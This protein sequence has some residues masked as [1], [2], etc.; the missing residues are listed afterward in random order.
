MRP[1]GFG[2]TPIR[3]LAFALAVAVVVMG[4]AIAAAVSQPWLGLDLRYNEAARGFMV[5]GSAGPSEAIPT[6]TVIVALSAG[7][8]RLVPAR[9]DLTGT[10]DGSFGP[11]AEYQAFMAKQGVYA[12]MM[13]QPTMTL[14]DDKGRDWTI[15]PEQGG[16][17]I[18]SLGIDFWIGIVTG[19]FSWLIAAA[20]FAFRPGE[21]SAHWVFV[22]GVSCLLFI[23]IGPI[24]TSRELGLP[25]TMF[26]IVNGMNALG[27]TIYAAAFSC[28][29]LYYPRKL[30]PLWVGWAILALYMVWYA[31]QAVG[32]FPNLTFARRIP[33]LTGV[34]GAAA[35][36][37]V[38]WMKTGRDPVARAAL[39]WFLVTWVVL[40]V[41][42][43]LLILAPQ[44]FGVDTGA[45]EPYAFLLF[46]LTFVGLAVGIMRYRLFELGA[47]WARIMVWIGALVLLAGLDM[48]FLVVLR[49][50]S[51]VSLSLA[52]L[53]CGIA[54]LP[55]RGFVAERMVRRRKVDERATF[56]GV[57]QIG[58]T[59]QGGDQLAQWT[60]VLK[61]QFDPLQI[62]IAPAPADAAR[63]E[64]DGLALVT[65]QV[66]GLPS[67]RLEYAHG[68]RT[69]FSPADV[70]QAR[71]LSDMLRFVVES[72]DAY[73]RGVTV[74]RKRIA[75]DI[76]DNLGATLLSALHSRDGE[77]K[78]RFIRETLA[79][80]RSIVTEPAGDGAGLVE[81]M[82]RSRKE[83]SERLAARGIALSWPL[84]GAPGEGVDSRVAQSLR[85]MLR[86][87]TNNILKHARATSV[88][89]A[90]G[91]A[92]G[93]LVLTVE[94]DGVGFDA[95]TV[96]AGAGL[97]GLRE[98]AAGHGG[99]VA[100]STGEG[101]HGTR[102]T[103]R[104]PRG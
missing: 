13:R 49:F 16:R 104:I 56:E 18:T 8:E 87:I 9:K 39:G 3:M 28:L 19:A 79:D 98:R 85:A 86:E 22:S 66:A 100:W 75:G 48:V 65:P 30:A 45:A 21:A 46:L 63:I 35:L 44:M 14:T 88:K 84:E 10:V 96:T 60:D 47:W 5:V 36:S 64:E 7:G 15:R 70:A 27:G 57:V 6:G 81:M 11:F 89:V 1:A 99:D 77:R 17:P 78:D 103:V 101:G 20:I 76:H 58:L 68:G 94:D 82:A 59:P 92:D 12:T 102:V 80:L 50:S 43:V 4:G 61:G 2:V 51:E 95:Q 83:M 52:L 53:V 69:L 93:A 97:G 34:A 71:A 74:E 62:D 31:A 91:E 33:A 37:V 72:R 29:L 67:L 42:F 40:A 32:M 24:Y 54:W 41:V 38:Q 55:L 25:E 26:Y 73:A 90:L 23:P